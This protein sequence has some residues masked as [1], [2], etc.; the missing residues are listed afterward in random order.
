[1]PVLKLRYLKIDDKW[2]IAYDANNNDKP[3]YWLRYDSK[4]FNFNESNAVVAM[5]YKLLELKS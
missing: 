1:M 5:F 4:Y 3:L 2:S